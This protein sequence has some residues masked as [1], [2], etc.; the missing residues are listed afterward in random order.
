MRGKHLG[1]AAALACFGLAALCAAAP[2]TR[3]QNLNTD[4]LADVPANERESEFYRIVDVPM[5]F[6][7]VMEAGSVLQLPDGRLAV[8]TRRGEI[9]FATGADLTPPA[10]K[11]KLFATG[12]TEIFGL[13]WRDNALYITQQSEIT[14]VRDTDNDGRADRFETVSDAWAWG[15]EHEYTFGSAFDRDGAIWT[16]HGLTGSYTSERPFRGWVLRNFP[17]GRWEPMA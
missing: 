11:W 16:V 10:P 14:R 3:P 15:G 8:G 17:D 6:D 13:A 1:F 12:Q 9:Y 7:G 5:P 2:T 4:D